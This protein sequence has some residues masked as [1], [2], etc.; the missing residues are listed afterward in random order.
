MNEGTLLITGIHGLVGQYLF[1]ILDSWNGRVVITGK[2]MCRLPDAAFTY[3]EMD[4]TDP[5]RVHEVFERYEPEVV[6]HTAAL[7][8]PDHC[9]LHRDEAI[10]VNLTGTENLLAAAE[11]SGSFFIYL[12]TDFVFSGNDGP[13]R[14]DSSPA[15]VNFYGETKLMA[16]EKLKNYPFKWAIVRTVLVYGNV[17]VGTR[18]NI[19]SWVK[20]ELERSNPIKVVSDQLR[21]TTYAGDLATALLIIAGKKAEGIWHISGADALS[22]WQ[23]AIHVADH[24]NLDRSLITK[25]DASVFS[26]PAKRPL[27]TPF[28]IDKACKE[29]GYQPHSFLE[30]MKLVLG[31]D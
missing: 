23:I 21:T 30:G 14:E 5:A 17:L 10:L 3:A 12:S 6:I 29:L 11:R 20:T 27:K 31:G 24:L 13:Y 26:Q 28:I 19:I 25:V 22:P 18:A 2:G 15:P 9:E 16:E 4:I 7:A 8:Q 1:K